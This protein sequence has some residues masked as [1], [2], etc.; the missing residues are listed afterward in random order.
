MD[1]PRPQPLFTFAPPPDFWS[2]AR[3]TV[4]GQDKPVPIGVRWRPLG[5]KALRAW[6][7]RV[8]AEPEKALLEVLTAWE[9]VDADRREI[10][11]DAGSLADF[12]DAYPLAGGELARQYMEAMHESRLGN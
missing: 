5:R 11:L 7:E 8:G 3:I 9:V 4:P 12:L 10:A 2:A 6:I 1:A